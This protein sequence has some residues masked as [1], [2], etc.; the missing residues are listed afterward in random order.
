MP[1][2]DWEK[3]KSCELSNR[4]HKWQWEDDNGLPSAVMAHCVHCGKRKKLIRI[5]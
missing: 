5:D 4:D 2:E 3:H 1:L